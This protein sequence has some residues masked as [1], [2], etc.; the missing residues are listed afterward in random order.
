[1]ETSRTQLRLA[2]PDPPPRG[3]AHCFAELLH[4]VF[5]GPQLGLRVDHD[6]GCGMIVVVGFSGSAATVAQRK[7]ISLG[8]AIIACNRRALVELE[9]KWSERDGEPVPCARAAVPYAAVV[10]LIRSAGR[11]LSLS[12]LT[13]SAPAVSP[14]SAAFPFGIGPSEHCIKTGARWACTE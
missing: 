6:P 5:Y 9:A 13:R 1:M 12:F 11:P 3:P 4:V 10:D 7:G 8:D 14:P 2:L